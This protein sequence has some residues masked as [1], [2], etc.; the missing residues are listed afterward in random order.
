[1][2]TKIKIASVTLVTIAILITFSGCAGTH[3]ADNSALSSSVGIMPSSIETS[4]SEQSS[5]NITANESNF[6][7]SYGE[8]AANLLNKIAAV[9]NT[10]NISDLKNIKAYDFPNSSFKVSHNGQKAVFYAPDQS[11]HDIYFADFSKSKP[12]IK[13]LSKL[14]N[15][16]DSSKF[17]HNF[18]W[19]FDDKYFNVLS[20]GSGVFDTAYVFDST[21]LKYLFSSSFFN[22]NGGSVVWSPNY[23][24]VAMPVPNNSVKFFSNGGENYSTEIVIYNVN[25]RSKRIVLPANSQ[26]FYL[27][28]IWDNNGLTASRVYRDNASYKDIVLKIFQ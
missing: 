1:M 21:T 5:S 6:A 12:I 10:N 9:A 28:V 24:S 16:G 18:Q 8:S 17:E 20:D 7:H 23:D 15:L 27:N 3:T 26:Y 25:K 14:Y 11:S 4:S 2:K 19:S 22:N 13:N